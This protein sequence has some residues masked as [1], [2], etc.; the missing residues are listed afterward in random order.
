VTVAT[1]NEGDVAVITPKGM[2]L[3][4]PEVEE[5]TRC[6]ESL[7]EDGNRKLLIDLAETVSMNS[8]AIAALLR[9]HVTYRDRDGSIRLCRVP[10]KIK[11]VFVLTKLVAVFPDHDTEAEALAAFRDAPPEGPPPAA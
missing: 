9:W 5:L 4:G 2:L 3:G 7:V 8:S 1:R 6:V 11:Q 10:V